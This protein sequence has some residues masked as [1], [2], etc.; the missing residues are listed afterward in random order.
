MMPTSMPGNSTNMSPMEAAVAAIKL[1]EPGELFTSTAIAHAHGV[2]RV[3]LA[4]RH[5]HSQV[6]YAPRQSS[7]KTS[8]HNRSWSWYNTLKD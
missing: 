8:T 3:T 7:N 4:Q 1:L 6:S 2:N 5:K